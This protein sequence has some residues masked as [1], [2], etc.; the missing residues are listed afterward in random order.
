MQGTPRDPRWKVAFNVTVEA[1]RS[2][3]PCGRRP[4]EHEVVQSG[5]EGGEGLARARG[6]GDQR[7]PAGMDLGPG[8]SLGSVGAPNRRS[9]HEDTAGWNEVRAI[10]GITGEPARSFRV[11]SA[12]ELLISQ[13]GVVISSRYED[14]NLNS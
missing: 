5:Q 14:G 11:V 6:R 7:V 10:T 13:D 3:E 9:N 8:A 2:S 12:C 1:R 4:A